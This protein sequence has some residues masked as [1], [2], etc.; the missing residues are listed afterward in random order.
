[1][2]HHLDTQACSRQERRKAEIVCNCLYAIEATP[3]VD[4]AIV[5]CDD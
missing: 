3:M 2:Q 4:Q 1:M 5:L